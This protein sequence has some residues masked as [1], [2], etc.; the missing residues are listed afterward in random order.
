MPLLELQNVSRSF[1]ATRALQDISFLLNA[2][3][4][5]GLV[6]ENGAGK[7]TLI[8]ILSGLYAPDSGVMI[9]KGAPASFT[10]P[11]AAMSAGIATIHQELA[12]FEKLTIAEN[13]LIGERWPRLRWGGVDWP[14]VNR[15]ASDRLKACGLQIDP[16]RFFYSLSPA[17]R[18][19]VAI[20]RVLPTGAHL[21]ILDEP[22]ASLTEPE[23]QRLIVQLGALQQKGVAILYVSHRLEEILQ[24]TQRVI[25]LRDGMIAAQYPTS[26]ASV[27]RIVRD[28][29]GRSL[30]PRSARAS[31]ERGEIIFNAI[32]LSRGDLFQ[33]VSLQVCAGEIVGLAGL[34]GAGRSE[35]ARA[36]FGLYPADSGTMQMEGKPYRP[37]SAADAHRSGIVYIP[38]ERKRQ[39]FVLEHSLLSSVSIGFLRM[40]SRFG[41][42]SGHLEQKRFKEIAALFQIKY[43]SPDQAVGTLSGGNQQ[44]ALLARSLQTNPRLVILDE[45][46]RGVD[47]GAKAEIYRLIATLADEGKAILLISSELS[48]LL[49]LSDRLVVLHEGRVTAKLETRGTS[50]EEILLAASG[51]GIACSA[52]ILD[53]PEAFR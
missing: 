12:G 32:N 53:E 37:T 21:V 3:E 33:N 16:R 36:V 22:T 28:M 24:L 42:V 35:F 31:P 27:G 18:Q 29:V 25:V 44:K 7:S 13:M 15:I 43:R 30:S 1:G 5:V 38:E 51:L 45:P 2:G 9:W 23:V 50:Q 48:E 41:I 6:G 47:V 39:G 34:I 8:K 52:D 49:A 4:V 20:A 10:N 46:T 17:Q 19:E 40:L 26:E 11:H 14:R